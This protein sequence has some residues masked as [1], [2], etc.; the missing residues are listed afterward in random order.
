MI[1][2]ISISDRSLKPIGKPFRQGGQ[3]HCARR[4]SQTWDSPQ[5]FSDRLLG[6]LPVLIFASLSLFTSTCPVFAEDSGSSARRPNIVLILADDLGY[7]DLHCYGH[8]YARTPNLDRLASE[9]TRFEQ[10]YSTGVTCCPARTGFMTSRWPASFKT[11]P[12]NG[13]FGDRITITEL[14]KRQGYRTGHFGK[15]HIGPDQT[16]GR[17]G[18]D[19][20]GSDPELLGKKRVKAGERG[21]DAPIFDAAIDFIENHRDQ[22][23]YLNVWGHISH[24]AVDPPQS[25]VDQF[26]DIVANAGDFSAYMA[27]KFDYLKKHDEDASVR[28][29]RYL[30]DVFSLDED[31][32]RL[33]QRIDDLGLRDNTIVVFSSDQGA[34]LDLVNQKRDASEGRSDLRLNMMG[35]VGGLRGGK[36]TMYEG[37]VRVPFIIRWPGHAKP[38]RVDKNSVTSGIDWLPTLCALAGIPI[39]SADF[40]GEDVSAAWLGNERRRSKPLLWKTSSTRSESA[41]R[42]GQWKLL[43]PFGKRGEVELFDIVADPAERNNL[44]AQRADVVAVL[45]ERL[46]RWNATLPTEYIKTGDKQD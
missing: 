32:G 18:I 29:R 23:F 25:Y 10:F 6:K 39:N 31:I 20:I 16:D 7:G 46:E 1:D 19:S 24:F 14:L 12:A 5:R 17:Y 40:E 37:G 27:V 38:G 33:L 34:P 36:H 13:G 26:S 41:I 35:Y 45:R 44:A 30:A 28:M 15:W 21:R 3:S 4:R 43:L 42:D 11:Y 8:P 22:P 9:G 2:S